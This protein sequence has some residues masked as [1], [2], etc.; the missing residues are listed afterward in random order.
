MWILYIL[1]IPYRLP[2]YGVPARGLK[3]WCCVLRA[4]WFLVCVGYLS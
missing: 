4:K 1:N 2:M 3:M